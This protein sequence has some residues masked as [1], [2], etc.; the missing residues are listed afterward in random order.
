MG[1]TNPRV[2]QTLGRE[3]KIRTHYYPEVDAKIASEILASC[4]FGWIDYFHRPD[5]PMP[6]ILK[7]TAFAAYCA[8]GVIPVFPHGGA[9]VALGRDALPGP[10]Y[11][12]PTGQ[13]LPGE[14]ERPTAA[15]AVYSWYGRNA[16]AVHLAATL[17]PLL[18]PA[19]RPSKILISSHAFAP[20]V[21]GIETVSELLAEEFVRLGH[22]VTVVTQTA[23]D[24]AEEPGYF[25]IRRPSVRQLFRAIKSCD[26]FWQNNLSLRTIWPALLLRKPI[27]ITHQGSYC[28][29]PS[30][31]DVV[32]RIKRALVECT[33]SVAISRRCGRMFQDEIRQ[34]FPIPMMR[35]NL[36]KRRPGRSGPWILFFSA[37]WLRKRASTCFSKHSVVFGSALCF[38]AS[39][40]WARGRNGLRWRNWRRNSGCVIK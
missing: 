40:S 2:R 29:Q 34:P 33:T 19:A 16:T 1:A 30:G 28:R 17:A 15:Q 3:K 9:T 13:E 32:Q 11:V 23:D 6:L 18:G 25:I 14:S 4:A 7:S 31:F 26:V 21:G 35:E 8:H 27:V 22:E 12:A 20:S 24:Q 5:V 38:L 37:V 36:S 10:F 39:P